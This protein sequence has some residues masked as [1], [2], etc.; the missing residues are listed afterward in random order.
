MGQ[1]PVPW[2]QSCR[3]TNFAK[4]SPI[5][6][7]HYVVLITLA[8]GRFKVHAPYRSGKAGTVH[9]IRFYSFLIVILN[10]SLTFV[11]FEIFKNI[12]FT[13]H[14]Y[15]FDLACIAQIGTLDNNSR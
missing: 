10:A 14:R 2:N 6:K 11:H 13:T 8:H 12:E 7:A 15:V 9:S 4:P 5:T 3:S 1:K